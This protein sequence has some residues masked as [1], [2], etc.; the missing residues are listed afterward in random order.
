MHKV[1]TAWIVPGAAAEYA[2][3]GPRDPWFACTIA[4]DPWDLGSGYVVVQVTIRDE[5]AYERFVGCRGPRGGVNVAF[6][7]PRSVA[8]VAKEG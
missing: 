5:D 7:R 2:P 8:P 4:S 6:L 3:V 1:D